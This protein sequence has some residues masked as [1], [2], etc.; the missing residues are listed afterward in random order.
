M[1]EEKVKSSMSEY[2]DNEQADLD[3]IANKYLTFELSAGAESSKVYGIQMKNVIEIVNMQPISEVPYAPEYVKGII[4]LRGRIVPLIDINDRFGFPE[5]PYNERTCIIVVNIEENYIGLIVNMVYEV[6]NI[7][8]ISKL[9]KEVDKISNKYV[10][11]IAK[12]EENDQTVLIMDTALVID[13]ET[14]YIM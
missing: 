7:K 3:D 1:D 6:V 10:S 5:T 13:Y 2:E 4:N 8:Q 9:P 12:N 11:G 14:D